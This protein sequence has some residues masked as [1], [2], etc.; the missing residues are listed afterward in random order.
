MDVKFNQA[1]SAYNT[2]SQVAKQG[3]IGTET[4]SSST[5]GS[6]LD[7]V[8]GSLNDAIHTTQK[9]ETVGAQALSGKAE[10]TDLVTAINEAELT[11]QTIVALRDRTINAYNDI[12]KMPI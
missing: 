6:F 2:A 12:V 1:A 4:L 11:V 10:L 3:G 9:A 5:D 8:Q 7:M